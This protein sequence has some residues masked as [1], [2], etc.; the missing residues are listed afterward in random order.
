[1]SAG[2]DTSTVT[3]GSTP[4]DGSLTMPAIVAWA[5]TM[6]GQAAA[7]ARSVTTLKQLRI[8]VPFI[9]ARNLAATGRRDGGSVFSQVGRRTFAA[10]LHGYIETPPTRWL[11]IT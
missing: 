3:P 1:M 10:R 9:S 6:L 4:P 8:A 11:G 7:I 5:R 2:L